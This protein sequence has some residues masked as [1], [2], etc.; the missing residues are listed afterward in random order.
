M[1]QKIGGYF[2]LDGA[3]NISLLDAKEH[4]KLAVAVVLLEC[5]R[6][7]HLLRAEER[8]LIKKQLEHRL[9]ITPHEASVLEAQAEEQHGADLVGKYGATL[10]QELTVAQREFLLTLAWSVI[11]SDGIVADAESQFAVR[12]RQMLGLSAEQSLRARKAAEGLTIDGTKELIE[13]SS[14]VH[15][16]IKDQLMRLH[17]KPTV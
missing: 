7:D 13:S 4:T 8:E 1:L 17:R 14:V 6:I 3:E 9:G 16:G 5:A 11:A 15:D 2:G 12:L 10:V